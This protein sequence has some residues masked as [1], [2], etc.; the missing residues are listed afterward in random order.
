MRFQ[1][2]FLLLPV[3]SFGQIQEV[4]NNKFVPV[5]NINRSKGAVP[6]VALEMSIAQKTEHSGPINDTMYVLR[7]EDASF[8]SPIF[9]NSQPL[10]ETVYF[11]GINNSIG[12][13]Y[14]LLKNVFTD[15]RYEEKDYETTLKL[16]TRTVVIRRDFYTDKT[17]IHFIADGRMFVIRNMKEL[18]EL[19][20]K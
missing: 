14:D 11:K 13:L 7:F 3:I 19:F 4:I 6:N 10:R 18:D 8:Q 9:S 12:Q 1:L 20:G 16:G 15:K 2:L 5:G 17:R